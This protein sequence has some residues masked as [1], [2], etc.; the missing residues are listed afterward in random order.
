MQS[1]D[2]GPG[3]QFGQ[4]YAGTIGQPSRAQAQRIAALTGRRRLVRGELHRS[5]YDR[6]VPSQELDAQIE[7][8]GRDTVPTGLQSLPGGPG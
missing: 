2:H 7:E 1:I 3:H 8:F 5:F 6:S 4:R